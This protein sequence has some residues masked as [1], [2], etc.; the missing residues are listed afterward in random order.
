MPNNEVLVKK[1]EKMRGNTYLYRT[2]NYQIEGYEISDLF[3]KLTTDKGPLN[4]PSQIIN[5]K[6]ADFLEVE[7]ERK[8]L[9][10]KAITIIETKSNGTEIT[11]SDNFQNISQNNLR[12][13]LLDQIKLVKQNPEYVKQAQMVNNITNTILKSFTVELALKKQLYKN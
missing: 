11:K 6:L 1:L 7:P 12:E 2:E 10:D 3:V 4:F 9:L 13:I 8:D 5:K